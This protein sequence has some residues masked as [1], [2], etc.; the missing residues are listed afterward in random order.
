MQQTGPWEVTLAITASAIGCKICTAV[1]AVSKKYQNSTSDI[2]NAL[3][4]EM[5]IH[6]LLFSNTVSVYR[7]L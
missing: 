3:K 5:K 7:V 1:V 2:L 4:M 6:H